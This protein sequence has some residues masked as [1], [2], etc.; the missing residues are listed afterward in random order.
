MFQWDHIKPFKTLVSKHLKVK[1]LVLVSNVQPSLRT[2][3]I[4]ND[5][6]SV[7]RPQQG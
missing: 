4:D 1:E 3:D 5:R 2:V 7:L 6:I